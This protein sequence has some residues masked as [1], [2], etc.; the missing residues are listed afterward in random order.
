V[1]ARGDVL[2]T[3]VVSRRLSHMLLGVLGFWALS[4]VGVLAA[5]GAGGFVRPGMKV[6]QI[7]AE[8]TADEG[9]KTEAQWL[10]D[11]KGVRLALAM[12]AV[13]ILLAAFVFWARR[14]RRSPTAGRGST[15]EVLSRIALSPKHSVVLVR[16]RGVELVLGLSGDRMTL[17]T[18]LPGLGGPGGVVL[19][20]E[21][22]GPTQALSKLEDAVAA[23]VAEPSGRPSIGVPGAA[24][25][26]AAGEAED[27]PPWVPTARAQPQVGDFLAAGAASRCAPS[28]AP[29][30]GTSEATPT[31]ANATGWLDPAGPAEARWAVGS[32]SSSGLEPYQRQVDRL[33]DLL[34]DWKA[35]PRRQSR[36]EQE[37]QG[38]S[39]RD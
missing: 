19:D 5:D 20:T 9:E 14:W 24:L 35:E 38:E 8:H 13:F 4:S 29:S 7:L 6:S 30:G 32:F 21:S 15:L 22:T 1:R 39:I 33:R 37:R 2:V 16:A 10:N 11:G 26:C 23:G 27:A 36:E 3:R 25:R 12:A 31:R 17:L 28:A 34:D 18:P